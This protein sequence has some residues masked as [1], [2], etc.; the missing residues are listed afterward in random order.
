M[1]WSF[2]VSLL[3]CPM[4]VV[5]GPEDLR[6]VKIMND[7]RSQIVSFAVAPTGSG[8]WRTVEFTGRPFDYGLAFTLA[9]HDDDGCVRDFRTMLSDGRRIDVRGFDLCGPDSRY[10]PGRF[11]HHGHQVQM[12][13]L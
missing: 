13:S 11:F 5:A 2:L 12:P 1:R 9:W 10:W 7:T 4:I 3:I 6:V 8:R